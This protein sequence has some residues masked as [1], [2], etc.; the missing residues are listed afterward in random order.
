M[1]SH[2]HLVLF[3][4]LWVVSYYPKA[5]SYDDL[6]SFCDLKTIS[7]DHSVSF[8]DLKVVEVEMLIK[9]DWDELQSKFIEFK[10]YSRL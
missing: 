6:I 7:Y 4:D 2:D 9:P 8:C 1:V 5:I 10:I 3:C